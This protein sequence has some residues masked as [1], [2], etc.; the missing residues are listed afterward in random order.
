MRNYSFDEVD[1]EMNKILTANEVLA[2]QQSGVHSPVKIFGSEDALVIRNSIE[3]LEREHG[4]LFT[5]DR[6]RPGKPI[7][8][9][10]RFKSHLLFKWLAD[11]IR[12]PRILDAVEQILGPDILCW[13]THWIIKEAGSPKFISWHQ[14]S[15]YWGIET[16]DFVSVWLAI[17]KASIE[18][19]CLR[20]L[21]GSHK[22]PTKAHVDTWAAENMLTRGQTI[23]N[24]DEESVVNLELEAGEAALF[25]YRLAHASNPN[26]SDDRRIGLGLRFIPPTASQVRVDWDSATLVRGEDRYG[27]FE[28]EPE[29]RCDL[30][31][32]A[33]SF[34]EKADATQR[35]IFYAGA[36]PPRQ[37]A[38]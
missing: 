33:V 28:L 18:S 16:E 27:N 19:G 21:P 9:S 2:Y 25:D 22:S 29:P 1:F 26:Q 4:P 14:D 7:Q 30:D 37:A 34:H 31:P 15:N 23:E 6:P 10:F 38:E 20:V 24:V 13:S 11:I 5:E 35:K 32:I 8:G 12:N 36:K 3:T 17:S